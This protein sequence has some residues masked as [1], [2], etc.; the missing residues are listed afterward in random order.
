MES[1]TTYLDE[2]MA[3]I[4]DWADDDTNN[5]VSSQVTF[6]LKSCMKLDAGAAVSGTKARRTRDVGTF[7]N[8]VVVEFSIY[9]DAIGTYV[10]ANFFRLLVDAPTVRLNALFGSDGLFI[11]DGAVYNEVGTNLVVQDTW[12]EWIFD[13]DFTTP[14]SAI[15]D[16]YLNNTLKASNVDCSCMGSFTNGKVWL[17]QQGTTTSYRLTYVDYIKVGDGFAGWVAKVLGIQ[18][19]AEVMGVAAANIAKV[20]GA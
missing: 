18:S 12:Q 17:T 2:D 7:G 15:V 8:R 19:P 10:A 11:N 3:D 20:M 5:G 16:I 13:I 14:A 1:N 9:C 4:S 6:D